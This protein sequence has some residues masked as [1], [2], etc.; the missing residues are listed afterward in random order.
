MGNEL[1]HS[2]HFESFVL[3]SEIGCDLRF[4]A[5]WQMFKLIDSLAMSFVHRG[6]YLSSHYYSATWGIHVALVCSSAHP[7]PRAFPTVAIIGPKTTTLRCYYLKG[8]RRHRT[9]ILEKARR[10]AQKNS[11]NKSLW[12]RFLCESAK[13]YN[14]L[15]VRPFS[16]HFVFSFLYSLDVCVTRSRRDY[17][18]V[19]V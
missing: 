6:Q 8:Y 13:Q 9:H 2:I 10:T 18:M 15:N 11:A 14:R 1:P 5:V 19:P 17:V 4:D 12:D 7:F 3:S 16:K